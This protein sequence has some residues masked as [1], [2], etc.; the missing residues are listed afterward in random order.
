[1]LAEVVTADTI[2]LDGVI[3]RTSRLEEEV[4]DYIRRDR[5]DRPALCLPHCDR[6]RLLTLLRGAGQ[7]HVL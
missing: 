1:M 2:G 6:D 7:T 5:L 3:V 4:L